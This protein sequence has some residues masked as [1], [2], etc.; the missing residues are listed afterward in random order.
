[1]NRMQHYTLRT[2]SAS[3]TCAIWDMMCSTYF[4]KTD[5]LA[6][7]HCPSSAMFITS[8]HH[9]SKRPS[10][11]LKQTWRILLS[12]TKLLIHFGKWA[13]ISS[14]SQTQ[15]GGR[16]GGGGWGGRDDPGH[17]R[18]W[19]SRPWNL[20]HRSLTW[21]WQC[22]GL[23]WTLYHR[24]D[25]HGHDLYLQIIQSVFYTMHGKRKRSVVSLLLPFVTRFFQSQAY[26]II[27]LHAQ[28][29]MKE[30]INVTIT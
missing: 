15:M 6:S 3:H 26:Y 14:F 1:M 25:W 24:K 9:V 21:R 17:F 27:C 7:P 12:A 2:T 23:W 10:K 20:S 28:I 30:Y 19:S 11:H 8:T 4:M 29:R 22:L 13:I 5:S 18:Q 16:E